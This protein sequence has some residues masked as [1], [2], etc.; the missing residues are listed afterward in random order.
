MPAEDC[1]AVIKKISYDS[2]TNSFVGLVPHLN[3]GIPTTLHYQTDSFK[4]LREWFS[5]RDCSHLINIHMIQ[6]ITNMQIAPKP[7]LLSAFGTNNKYEAIDIIR[8]WIWI[9]EQSH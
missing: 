5:T 7:F 6:P 4:K 1:T 9:F 3:D 8:R 2:L